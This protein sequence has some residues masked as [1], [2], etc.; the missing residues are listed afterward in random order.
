MASHMMQGSWRMTMSW[1]LVSCKKLHKKLIDLKL[2]VL[3]RKTY[4]VCCWGKGNSAKESQKSTKEGKCD[5]DEHCECCSKMWHMST[6]CKSH[7]SCL[8][9]VTNCP[10][11][12]YLPTYKLREMKRRVVVGLKFSF[13]TRTVSIMSNTGIAY[14]CSRAKKKT[15]RFDQKFT[16][17]IAFMF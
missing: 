13:F 3:S 10:C 12:L 1:G 11:Y 15:S 8:S 7:R 5:T 16:K 14:S 6:R 17:T 9:L 4:K 2:R